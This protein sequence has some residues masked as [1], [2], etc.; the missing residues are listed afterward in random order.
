MAYSMEDRGLG[1]NDSMFIAMT[2]VLV[3]LCRPVTTKPENV[4]NITMCV[5]GEG[6]SLHKLGVNDIYLDLSILII[7]L[8]VVVASS[9]AFLNA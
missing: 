2:H 6:G 5:L 4:A 7:L 3:R 9:F 8:F 1:V